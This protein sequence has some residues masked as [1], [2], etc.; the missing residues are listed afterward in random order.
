MQTGTRADVDLVLTGA[1]HTTV[2]RSRQGSF[3]Q[4]W[5]RR[6]VRPDIGALMTMAQIEGTENS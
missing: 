4:R 2:L 6:V 3:L 5:R 1:T